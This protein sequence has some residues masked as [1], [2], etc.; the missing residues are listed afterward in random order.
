M[1]R[2]ELDAYVYPVDCSCITVVAKNGR[3]ILHHPN[4]N[5][6]QEK[7]SQLGQGLLRFDQTKIHVAIMEVLDDVTTAT[8]SG[9]EYMYATDH[10]L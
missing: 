3:I 9:W 1:D 8:A 4:L 5:R 10:A 7:R 6:Y 2:L